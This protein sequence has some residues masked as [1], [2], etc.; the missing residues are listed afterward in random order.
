MS[1]PTFQALVLYPNGSY[2]TKTLTDEQMG[3]EVQGHLQFLAIRRK[4][5]PTT[6]AYVNE[7]GIRKNLPQS[8]WSGFF[9]SVSLFG[10][11]VLCSCDENGE[12][13]DVKKEVILAVETYAYH[14]FGY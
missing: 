8:A 3:Q 12:N 10:N 6:N 14:T 9:R 5:L 4:I 2:A 1:T 7:D 11:I 13:A